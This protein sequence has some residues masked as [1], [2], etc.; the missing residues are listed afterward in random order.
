M[1]VLV[2]GSTGCIG[3]AVVHALRARGHR[4]IEAARNACT[5]ALPMQ[6]VLPQTRTLMTV[7]R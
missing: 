2:C 3:S 7:S 6:P 4:V 5:T 1:R